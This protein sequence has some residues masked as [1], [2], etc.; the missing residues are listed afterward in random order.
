MSAEPQLGAWAVNKGESPVGV[1]IRV[2]MA[3][4]APILLYL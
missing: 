3:V 4:F 1:V 2:M